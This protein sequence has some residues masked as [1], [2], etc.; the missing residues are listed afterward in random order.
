VKIGLIDFRRLRAI[1]APSEVALHQSKTLISGLF[2]QPLTGV[3]ASPLHRWQSCPMLW[4]ISALC[5]V[6][7]HTVDLGSNRAICVYRRLH[8][9]RLEWSYKEQ[10]IPGGESGSGDT[11]P[12]AQQ[13]T[14]LVHHGGHMF[15]LSSG[16]LA[17]AHRQPEVEV[18]TCQRLIGEHQACYMGTAMA[19]ICLLQ[20]L[21]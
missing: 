7:H 4:R 13:A 3:P 11:L 1:V 6:L 21:A 16:E 19:H 8:A 20:P 14:D 17:P 2:K 5:V 18:Y 15:V 9:L 12:A 10:I